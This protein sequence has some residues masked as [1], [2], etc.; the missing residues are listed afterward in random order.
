[1]VDE[2]A[3]RDCL[4]ARPVSCGSGDATFRDGKAV[5]R[6]ARSFKGRSSWSVVEQRVEIAA[7]LRELGHL[8]TRVAILEQVDSERQ[9]VTGELRE[10]TRVTETLNR[11]GGLLAAE[12]D[13][14]RLVQIVTDETTTLIG[15]EFGA[16]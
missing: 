2:C 12:L 13:L 10:E 4:G 8:R 11:I 6:A 9:R 5:C 1:M 7:L 15:A 16:F 3:T 14:Q